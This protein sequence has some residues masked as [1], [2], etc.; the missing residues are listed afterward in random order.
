MHNQHG[1]VSYYSY[2]FFLW[3]GEWDSAGQLQQQ[4]MTHDGISDLAAK[5]QFILLFYLHAAQRCLLVPFYIWKWEHIIF[6]AWKTN[7]ATL[8]LI[9]F[10]RWR[11]KK[12]DEL[13]SSI[14][15][16][17]CWLWDTSHFCACQKHLEG[18]SMERWKVVWCILS[19]HVRG[20]N[21]FQQ[22][23]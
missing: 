2:F 12:K 8:I 5:K 1:W 6:D 4:Q 10:W 13:V 17:E 19:F 20:K 21:G 22:R 14:N 18:I 15:I 9:G 16:W 23:G 11:E 7:L 3:I